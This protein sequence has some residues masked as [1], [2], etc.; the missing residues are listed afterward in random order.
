M[1]V[2]AYERVGILELDAHESPG[3]KNGSGELKVLWL[4]VFCW[5]KR[6]QMKEGEFRAGEKLRCSG[7]VAGL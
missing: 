1:L 3:L 7:E 2:V 6:I 4:G 5:Y